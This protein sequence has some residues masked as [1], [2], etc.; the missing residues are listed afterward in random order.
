MATLTRPN[1]VLINCDD[2]GYG[3]PGCYGSTVNRT[4][5]LDRM[6][7]EG[8]RFTDFYMASPV[9]SP[10][11]GAMM[12][13]C[14]PPRIGFDSFDGA[15]VLFPGQGVGLH[16]GEQT[17]AGLLKEQGY[18]TMI[19]G[20]WHCG[21]Q[22]EF[23]PTRHGFDHYYGLP[24]S[25]DMG[26][27]VGR[28]KYPPLPLLRDEAI[29]QEQ[30]DQAALTERYTEECVRFIRANKDRPFFLY[31]AHMYVHR[32]IYAPE[33]F[34]KQSKNGRYGAGVECVDWSAGVILHELARWGLDANTLMLFT[35]DNGSRARDEGGSN[36]PL[37]GT[38]ATTWEGGQRV[39]C[40]MRWPA[41]IPAGRVCRELVTAMDFLPTFVRLAGGK[42]PSDRII[43]GKDIAAL[44]LGADGAASPHDAFFYYWKHNLDAVRSGKWKLHLRKRDDALREL[45]DLDSDVGETTNVYADHPDVVE[46]L[47]AKID[48]C[49]ADL[50]DAA[51]GVE[52]A[53]RRPIG[54]VDNPR[55]LTHYDPAHP[56]IE[57]LYD[58]KDGG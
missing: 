5:V 14:Y 43:D 31:L 11:R 49:R 12:T 20:K 17:I 2:L 7:A 3:D 8:I 58:L 54:R 38:K 21:D 34:M 37:R 25:N 35:S 44:M 42:P 27:Q 51:T 40:I 55:P 28:E 18:A 52:G 56:Y 23:L 19:V 13:G 53:N 16:A 41:A 36:A 22:P 1:I 24:Y 4:P 6:A 39:P 33:R 10:S 57:A 15:A 45:Y 9:C 50:G 48:A 29:M 32:P 30:P 26:R 47:L 46:A